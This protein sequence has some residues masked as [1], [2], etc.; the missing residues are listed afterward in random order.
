MKSSFWK[1][2]YIVAMLTLFMVLAFADRAVLGFAAV[3]LMQD[4][5]LAPSEFGLAASAMYWLY[6]VAGLVGGFALNKYPAKWVLALLATI[7]ALSQFPMLWATTASEIIFARAL[8]GVGEGPAFAVALHACFKWFEDK[9]RAV[10]TSIVSEGAAFGI[11]FASP[12][13]AYVIA[14]HGWRIGF[15]SLAVATLAWVMIWIVTGSEGTVKPV[16]SRPDDVTRVS[17]RLLLLDRTFLGNTI[18]GFSVACG[19][20]IFLAWLPPYLLKGL[21]YSATQAGWLT[22]LPWLSSIILV[23]VGSVLSQKLLRRSVS[24]R[25][26]RGLMLS[27][28]LGLGGLATIGMTYLQPGPLQLGLLSIGF[29]LPTLVWT[30]SPAIIGEVTPVVQRGAMLAIFTTV[31]NTAAGSLAPYFMGI[32]VERGATQAAG[33]ATGFAILGAIQ[34]VVA[35]VAWLMIDP[36]ATRSR[37]ASQAPAATP[38]APL[39]AQI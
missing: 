31:S 36:E 21:G 16:T 8:L 23:L 10:P 4:L 1:A 2:W 33:Y 3:P 28:A 38:G 9:D 27:G 26:A 30:L 34:A 14:T 11:I 15:A 39:P 7:W 6:P 13:V 25:L 37:F 18:A 12:V 22:T 32:L 17:Y 5:K 35:V 19:I 24:S 20:T 29:G